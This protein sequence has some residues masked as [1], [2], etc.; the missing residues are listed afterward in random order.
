[1]W[2]AVVRDEE[3][4]FLLKPFMS[5]TVYPNPPYAYSLEDNTS[6]RK[7]KCIDEDETGDQNR[8]IRETIREIEY[9]DHDEKTHKHRFH[10]RENFF[11]DAHDSLY[12]VEFLKSKDGTDDTVAHESYSE[13][14]GKL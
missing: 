11:D 2:F 13:Q 5:K 3:Y 12:S 9:T 4:F 7:Q 14:I 1:M 6:E 8:F 10:N